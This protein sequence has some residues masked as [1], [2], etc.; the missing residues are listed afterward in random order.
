MKKKTKKGFTLVELLVVVAIIGILA[1][2]GIV[3]ITG[4]RVRARDAKRVAD[5]KSLQSALE[6]YYT[7]KASYPSG[8]G[9]TLG[10]VANITE[11]G[12]GKCLVLCSGTQTTGFRPTNDCVEDSVVYMGFIPKDPSAPG[13]TDCSGGSNAPCHYAYTAVGDPPTGYRIWSYLEK[14]T[15][16]L[17]NG[18]VCATQNGMKNA[19]T[20]DECP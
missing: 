11:C 10:D 7:D 13:T 12:N 8:S 17:I 3:A 1:A 16:G 9:L 2:I 20:N 5:I 6:L 18:S 4:A 15:G 14:G 19:A